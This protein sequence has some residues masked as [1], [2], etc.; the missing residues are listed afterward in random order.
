MIQ[1]CSC[2]GGGVHVAH[3]GLSNR[4]G[5]TKL[6][7]RL[8]TH[9]A[10]RKA[11]LSRLS[12]SAYPE[13]HRLRT[14][15]AADFSIAFLDACATVADVLCFYQ[16]RL[17]NEGYIETAAER[18]SLL[19]LSRLIGYA[20]RPGVSA[21]AYLAY[22][23]EKGA[24][25]A[26]IP[27]G[28]KASTIPGPGEDMQAFETSEALTAHEKWNS[29]KPRLTEP[30]TSASIREEKLYL[31]GTATQ[32]K[33]GDRL[34][35]KPTADR[36]VWQVARV[37]SLEA[38][39]TEKYTRVELK[40]LPRR[41]SRPAAEEPSVDETDTASRVGAGKSVTGLSSA[42]ISALAKPAAVA[43]VG[44][45]ELQR[46]AAKAFET[47]QETFPRLL[48]HLQPA[49]APTLYA[50]WNNAA[51]SNPVEIEVFALRIEARPF[52]H[53][54]PL[55]FDHLDDETRRPVMGEWKASEPWNALTEKEKD[56]PEKTKDRNSETKPTE[57][58]RLRTLYLDNDYEVSSLSEIVIEDRQDEVSIIRAVSAVKASI[59]AY[60]LSGKT[61]KIQWEDLPADNDK[62]SKHGGDLPGGGDDA[63]LA[64]DSDFASVRGVRVFAGGEKLELAER[65]IKDDICG[66]EIELDGVYEGLEAGQWLIVNGERTDIAGVTGIYASELVMLAGVEHH[67][68]SGEGGAAAGE[69]Y[70]SKITLEA[71]SFGAEGEPRPGLAYCYKR[72]TVTINAN[73][74]KATH[75]ETRSEVLGSGK[76]AEAFQTIELKQFPLTHVSAPTA[77]GIESTLE[78]LVNGVAWRETPS[79]AGENERSRRFGTRT[80]DESRTSVMFGDGTHGQRLPTGRENIRAAYRSG[81]GRQG[82]VKAKQ[83]SLLSS[84]P[85]GVK[86]VINPVRASGGADRESLAAI[87]SNAP[88]SVTAFDRLVSIEDYSDFARTFGGVGKAA[89]AQ[90]SHPQRGA[91]L[92]VTIAGDGDD[93]VEEGSDLFRNLRQALTLYGD[94]D[95]RIHLALRKRW[96]VIISAK[97]KVAP[98]FRWEFVEPV[99]RAQLLEKF[100]FER[101]E[102]GGTLFRSA[103]FAAVQAV[104]GVDYVDIDVFDALDETQV[105][106]AF[107]SSASVP[108]GLKEKISA[109]IASYSES[110]GNF[111]TAGLAYL[112]PDMKDTLIL[113]E[114]KS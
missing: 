33:P 57:F 93:P 9:G 10:F 28:S 18:R 100:G 19:E 71:Q 55:R 53:N 8:G 36:A 37:Q 113:Q 58:H 50:A 92:H 5:L 52:G 16:E 94:E 13:L 70:H 47:G 39:E 21:S 99:I 34:L 45:K 48:T 23:L 56:D 90:V 62:K 51:P 46:S 101:M 97:V 54:A 12:S 14:R 42:V 77:S 79:L 69:T 82:N 61:V 26:E 44:A 27:K 103:V 32:L 24:A 67:L 84:R 22:T 20:P 30:Q 80:D 29:I 111:A 38:I 110:A 63:W 2:C 17:A 75:G 109:G 76:A 25:K 6:D 86:E 87:R 112:A 81:L 74:V 31:K 49:V 91:V 105:K 68:E 7:Y 106:A 11:M 65:P 4:P 85:L 66:E 3:A 35:L 114:I 104:E 15:D 102:L 107:T 72:D 41:G 98:D 73:V 95:V 59:S 43:P 64:S 96:A 40:L 60:G 89:A 78:V 88:A 1:C 83:I 108:L